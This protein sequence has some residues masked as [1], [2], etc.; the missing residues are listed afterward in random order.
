MSAAGFSEAD[1]NPWFFGHPSRCRSQ[2]NKA[3]V[4]QKIRAD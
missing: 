1:Q 4:Q 2:S 3:G